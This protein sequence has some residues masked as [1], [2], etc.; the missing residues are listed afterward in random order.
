M[1][2]NWHGNEDAGDLRAY[3]AAEAAAE[4]AME[5]EHDDQIAARDREDSRLAAESKARRE[6]IGYETDLTPRLDARM[7]RPVQAKATDPVAAPSIVLPSLGKPAPAPSTV[8]GLERHPVKAERL[9]AFIFAGS[10]VFTL[11]NEKSGT[12]FTYRFRR[13]PAD[14]TQPEQPAKDRPIFVHV[15]TGPNNSNDYSYLGTVW[16][17]SRGTGKPAF[18]HGKKSRISADA[19]SAKGVAWLVDKLATTGAVPEPLR[20]YH[21]GRCGRC[22]RALTV[23]ESI[24]TGLG[25]IC[26]EKG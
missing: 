16:E 5:R 10:C 24:E 3:D 22:G 20:V 26:A 23:P 9:S 8:S 21:E 15:L 19:P 17:S 12:R 4:L 13:A 14:P 2:R 1:N 18:V 7:T 25:P 6:R 11:Q